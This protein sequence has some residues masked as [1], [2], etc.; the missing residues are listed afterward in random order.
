MYKAYELP[1]DDVRFFAHFQTSLLKNKAYIALSYSFFEK[2]VRRKMARLERKM[3]VAADVRNRLTMTPRV[4][5]AIATE[6]ANY[7]LVRLNV[8]KIAF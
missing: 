6:S 8:R 3:V 5:E 1:L 2:S 7:A 4:F